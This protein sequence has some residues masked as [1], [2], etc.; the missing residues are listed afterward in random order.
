MSYQ[1]SQAGLAWP[2]HIRLAKLV[3]LGPITSD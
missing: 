1:T 2:Y 3:L